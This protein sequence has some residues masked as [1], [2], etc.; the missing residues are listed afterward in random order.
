ML[1]QEGV[2]AI[3]KEI[4]KYNDATEM[5]D[6]AMTFARCLARTIATEGTDAPAVQVLG[7]ILNGLYQRIDTSQ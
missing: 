6:M 2:D 1:N 4:A 3:T 5:D 7:E